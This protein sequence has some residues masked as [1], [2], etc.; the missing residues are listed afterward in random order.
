M[1]KVAKVKN[2]LSQ[3]VANQKVKRM[4]RINLKML[5]LIKKAKSHQN[6]K[7]IRK[8]NKRKKLKI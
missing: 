7:V 3:K 1:I 4:I 2:N 6:Q 5:K 8:V